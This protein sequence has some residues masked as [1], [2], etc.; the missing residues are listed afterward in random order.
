MLTRQASV[1]ER[2]SRAF[3]ACG[4]TL[5]DFCKVCTIKLS[6]SRGSLHEVRQKEYSDSPASLSETTLLYG[7]AFRDLVFPTLRPVGK[8]EINHASQR[9]HDKTVS[10]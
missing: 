2:H 10:V 1:C 6:H 8:S 5:A 7:G 9:V 3:F 4:Q